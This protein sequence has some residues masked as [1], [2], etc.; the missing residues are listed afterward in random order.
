MKSIVVPADGRSDYEVEVIV[1]ISTALSRRQ[2]YTFILRKVWPSEDGI[3]E[4]ALK[5]YANLYKDDL[6]KLLNRHCKREDIAKVREALNF[7]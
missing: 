1:R 6:E 4:A 5:K 3:Y 7:V 2:V